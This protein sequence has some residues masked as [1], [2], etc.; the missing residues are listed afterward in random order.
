MGWEHLPGCLPCIAV[1]AAYDSR[2]V[3]EDLEYWMEGPLWVRGGIPVIAVDGE[4]YE[5]RN[6]VTLSQCGR[7]KNMLFCDRSH[8]EECRPA[9]VA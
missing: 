6:G 4:T 2:V 9:M 5:V 7:S 8:L 3:T 1:R